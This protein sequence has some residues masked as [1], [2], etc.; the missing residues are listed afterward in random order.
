[1][2]A[3]MSPLTRVLHAKALLSFLTLGVFFL[4]ILSTPFQIVEAAGTISG[5]AFRDYNGNGTLDAREPGIGD[6][7]VTVY[8]SSNAARGTV[9]TFPVVCAAANVPAG[10]FNGRTCTGAGTPAL[11]SWTI[12]AGGTGPYRVEFTGLPGWLQPAPRSTDSVNGGTATDS[13]TSLQFVQ[14]G[15]TANVNFA[16]NDPAQYVSTTNPTLATTEMISGTHTGS[17]LPA[18]VSF[19]YNQT[20]TTA[21]TT[22]AQHQQVGSTWG[23]AYSRTQ[24]KYY[25]SAFEKRMVDFGPGGS[26]AIYSI[27][28]GGAADGTLFATIPG[29]GG[30][31]SSFTCN[32][33]S[34]S[35][36]GNSGAWDTST[37]TGQVG[38][39][40]LGA[41]VLSDDESTL[42]T[43][44]LATK[45]LDSITV[46]GGV[47][48]DIGA[49]PHPTCTN[50]TDRPFGLGFHDGKLYMGGVCDASSAGTSANL[51]AY[52]YQWDPTTTF[53]SASLALSFAL[54]YD[55]TCADQGGYNSPVPF[56]DVNG[57]T[58]RGPRAVW[59][60]WSDNINTAIATSNAQNG[61]GGSYPMPMLT[62]I[63]FD[64]S[65]MIVA[66]RDRM[67]DMLGTNDPGPNS[68]NPLGSN[69][70]EDSAG[71]VLRANPCPTSSSTC[72][73]LNS[74]GWVLESNSHSNPSGIF[75]P[76]TQNNGEGPG[77]G[78]TPYSN[79]TG[80]ARFFIGNDGLANGGLT[81]EYLSEG[82]LVQV[83]GFGEV[84][85]TGVDPINTW[86]N[87]EIQ[88][89]NSTGARVRSYQIYCTVVPIQNPTCTGPA[90]AN[91]LGKANGLGDVVALMS[92]AP[93]ELG[94]RVW[95]D[96]NGNG[97]QD[98]GESAISGVTVQLVNGSNT[99]ISTAVTDVNGEYYF[100]SASGTN[101]TNV[102]Y[103]VGISPNTS[104]TVRINPAVGNNSTAL[105]GLVITAPNSDSSAN[106]DLR[107]SDASVT[108]GNYD[109]ALTTGSAGANNHTYDF[110]FTSPA[111]IGNR[112]WYDTNNN[113]IVDVGEVGING[114]TVN[115]YQDTNGNG[116]FDSGTD[117]LVA[118][119]TTAS[120]GGI[121]GS[122]NFTNLTPSNGQTNT[123]YLVVLPAS[124]FSGG[125][126]ANYQ[127]SSTVVG[128]NLGDGTPTVDNKNHG[129]ASGTLGG[130]GFVASNAINLTLTT[131]PNSAA[132][133]DGTNGN[134]TVDFGFYKMTVTGTVFIDNVVNNGSL[135]SGETPSGGV[136]SGLTVRLYKDTNGNGIWDVGDTVYMTTTTNSTGVYTFTSII[137]GTYIVNVSQPTNWHSTIDTANQTDSDNPNTGVDN[138]DNGHGNAMGN[139]YSRAFTMTPGDT[140]TNQ[141][142]T[143]NNSTGTT[144]DPTIDFGLSQSPTAIEVDGLA[145]SVTSNN[146]VRLK[147]KT[148]SE[149]N[150]IGF[151]ILRAHAS[152][153]TYA[154]VNSGLLGAKTPGQV[155]GNSY[156][157]ADAS[158]AAGRTYYYRIQ[159]V[160]PDKST[161]SSDPVRVTVNLCASQLA[162]PTLTLPGA[163]VQVQAG[164]ITFAW[165]AV[166]CAA[167]YEIQIRLGSASGKLVADAMNVK[168]TQYSIKKLATG[169]HYVWRVLACTANG[170]CTAS[171]WSSFKVVNK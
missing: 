51:S 75:G 136:E 81:Q 42:Y 140:T 56:C 162:A 64:N 59:N 151:N 103:G 55:R 171:A 52:V 16:V 65:D 145:A 138:N 107:D 92:L 80:C 62:K 120:V 118:S 99:V 90:V 153:G 124:D 125:A 76:T 73:A 109:I 45:H 83:P 77:S 132:D 67:G 97:I 6:I 150:V 32:G 114:V 34:G 164:K 72:T 23:I 98:A 111:N 82:G 21:P 43:I 137:S 93:I 58:T 169:S 167:G 139:V 95:N 154:Q 96:A 46:P 11:G 127:P 36:D 115:L 54:N 155:T 156:S 57:T 48:G 106:G 157:F 63:Q 104:Y 148:P 68:T 1:M 141:G 94:N 119:T 126:L 49:V 161:D 7:T 17:T 170:N 4:A 123:K 86:S 130:S 85:E 28:P 128:S 88:L 165:N 143:V 13:G 15:S 30:G 117:T 101:T 163:G 5:V 108:S 44:N 69:R 33:V 84:V 53:A 87:G 147:W 135:D 166:N 160:H 14:D 146:A 40:S 134:L 102:Q 159:V 47:A 38:K 25:V 12:T 158:V 19:P 79:G 100:S 152:N 27:T 121:T 149:L 61:N 18:V 29:A 37:S 71:D 91:T 26:G 129:T 9:N 144:S 31:H 2:T 22:E 89:N 142:N 133:G 74:G 112:V 78:C 35:C 3:P 66:L 70:F 39:A 168:A 131:Q 24:N 113:G 110:G 41:L 122:Y 8:D 10:T 116:V 20:G 105:T 50:G 60:P